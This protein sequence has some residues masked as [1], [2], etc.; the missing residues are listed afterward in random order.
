MI[1]TDSITGS[2]CWQFLAPVLV[3]HHTQ[4]GTGLDSIY[5]TDRDGLALMI[6]RADSA[7]GAINDAIKSATKILIYA[8]RGELADEM[9]DI[10]WMLNGLAELRE[11]VDFARKEAQFGLERGRYL[12]Q[13]THAET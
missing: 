2:T 3:L 7:S 4:K 5:Q 11:E 9:L 10:L 8:E 1:D 13:N 6:R 12:E